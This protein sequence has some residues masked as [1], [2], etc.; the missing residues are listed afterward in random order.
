MAVKEDALV[1]AIPLGPRL[2]GG[3]LGP[4][5]SLPLANLT[6]HTALFA[7]SGSGKTVLLRRIVEE[8]ALAGIPAIVLDTNN[9][10]A[11]L[12][13]AWPQRPPSFTDEDAEKAA[14]YARDV[15]VVLWTPGVAA[16][17]PLT[18]AVLPDFSAVAEGEER[19]QAID[20]A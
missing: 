17:R 18:L 19:T 14:R 6:R 20:M 3:G 16:G 5:E 15:E 8:A 13:Q 9:D 2:Q 11:R 7:G 4:V 1:S 10:L 12:G